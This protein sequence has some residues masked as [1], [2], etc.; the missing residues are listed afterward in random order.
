MG[1]DIVISSASRS[2]VLSLQRTERDLDVTSLRLATG[3]KVNSALD[4]PQN[5]FASLALKNDASDYSRL[6]D[7]ISQ[8]A[9]TVQEAL[10]GIDAISSL[11]DQGE[12]VVTEARQK[13]VLGEDDASVFIEEVNTSPQSLSSQILGANPDVYYQ[14]NDGGGTADD[15][16]VG[17]GVN[18]TYTGGVTTGAPALYT[19]GGTASASFDGVNDRVRVS[20]SP[21]INVGARTE[22][23]VELVFNA[24]DITSRQVL[25]E[26][27]GTVNSFNIYIEGGLVHITGTDQGAWGPNSPSGPNNINFPINLNETYHVAFVFSQAENR[28]EGYVNG[29]S[30]GSV[31]V[32]NAVFPSHTGNIGIGALE[33]G[34]WFDDIVAGGNGFN[35]NGSISDVAIYNT[36]LTDAQIQSHAQSL[37]AT[38]TE[39]FRHSDFENILDQIDQITIDANYRGVNLL[40]DEDLITYFNPKNTSSLLTEGVD[41]TTEA[42]GIERFDFNDIDDI[43]RILE[44]LRDARDTVREFGRTFVSD[45]G[46]IQT[47]EDYTREKINTFESGA[48]DLTIADQNEEGANLLASQIRQQLG[49]TSLSLASQSS[50][51]VL[52]LF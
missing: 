45:L 33:G 7:G 8:S 32:G 4:D 5:F 47:R 18:A 34:A 2:T 10:I 20:D 11:V 51:S 48:N 6:I 30:V 25:Y 42:L 13:L 38:V 40:R 35:F 16:G 9:R 41:L 44:S 49:V 12:A 50:Q 28:F 3:Q 1:N 23:T 37:N 14:L 43:D 24:N 27:G 22:R 36:N 52:N 19:N 21:L 15:S 17:G 31:S 29:V 26:E 39:R 46:I